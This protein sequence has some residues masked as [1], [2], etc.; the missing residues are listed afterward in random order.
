MKKIYRLLKE[1]VW[2][3]VP[4]SLIAVLFRVR[5][6]WRIAAIKSRNLGAG[7][8]IS[9]SAQVLGW[10]GVKIG[11]NSFIG[12]DTL[13]IVNNKVPN[14]ESIR[15]GANCLIGRRNY[16]S[17]GGGVFI[18]DYCLTAPDCRVLGGGH[19]CSSPYKPY[20]TT[21]FP[22]TKTIRIGV[23]C[24]LGTAVSV[25]DG[26]SIGHGCVIGAG[27]VVNHDI[28]PFSIAIGNPARV[29]KRFNPRTNS[30]LSPEDFTEEL[31]SEL[32][33]EQRY[34]VKL[35]EDY[36]NI[37]KQFYAATKIFGDMP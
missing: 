28:P 4:S 32:P 5:S 15:I 37:G 22:I 10:G 24:W 16:I 31:T 33:D 8:F 13:V 14:K 34:L 21:G 6:Y 36:P 17:S 11:D 29:I 20:I 18:G 23:N 19:D 12:D 35:A 1:S 25:L 9:P 2:K 26:V 7:V 30:W 27:T 3:F